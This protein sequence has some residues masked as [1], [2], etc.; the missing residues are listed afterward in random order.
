M[1]SSVLVDRVLPLLAAGVLSGQ[2]TARMTGVSRGTVAAIARGDHPNQRPPNSNPAGPYGPGDP[3]EEEPPRPIGRCGRCGAMGELPCRPCDARA[4]W[5]ASFV[6]RLA[7][8]LAA[9]AEE[10]LDLEL[11]A[12]EHARYL[13]I[14]RRAEERSRAR[15]TSAAG[16]VSARDS[17]P[18]PDDPRRQTLLFVDDPPP[19]EIDDAA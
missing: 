5:A 7:K 15:T 6:H 14:R 10:P 2:Q 16:H 1:I 12:E 4:A 19:W 18:D 11:R 3:D 13:S 9:A 8:K 17:F